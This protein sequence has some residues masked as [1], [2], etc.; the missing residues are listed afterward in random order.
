MAIWIRKTAYWILGVVAAC[1][2][3]G[4][5]VLV[6][7]FFAD[8]RR[9]VVQDLLSQQIGQPLIIQT[10]VRAFVAPTTHVTVSG[11]SIPSEA[12]DGL[13]LAELN[14]LEFDLDLVSMITGRDTGLDNVKINGLTV[15]LFTRIDGVRSWKQSPQP[16]VEPGQPNPGGV[17]EQSGIIAFL[18]KK[19]VNVSS[20][21]LDVKNETT[22]FE[23][24]FAL[25]TARLEQQDGGAAVTLFSRGTV[26]DHPMEVTGYYPQGASFTTS[27][28]L[29]GIQ[30]TFDGNRIPEDAGGG[31]A[32]ILTLD[33]GELGDL[34]EVLRLDR[35]LEGTAHLTAR[36]LRQGT[37]LAVEDLGI[38]ADFPNG[39]TVAVEGWSKDLFTATDFDLKINGQF[40]PDGQQPRTAS[41]LSELELVSLAARLI[42]DA[43]DI[44]VQDALLKTNLFDAG[45]DEIGPISVGR[46]VRTTAGTLA[47]QNIEAQAGP[48]DSPYLTVAGQIEDLLD[49]QD[50]DFSGELNA[51]AQ[52]LMSEFRNDVVQAFGGI[53][54][55]FEISDESGELSLKK[56]EAR[57]EN[58]DLWTMRANASARSVTSVDEVDFE[59]DLDVPDG[60]AFLEAL[61]LKSVAIG[62]VGLSTSA[63]GKNESVETRVSVSV[64]ESSIDTQLDTTVDKNGRPTVRGQIYSR[65]L[66]MNDLD[67][68]GEAVVQL[69]SLDNKDTGANSAQ[70]GTANGAPS[71][72]LQPLVLD[73]GEETTEPEVPE[74]AEDGRI[75]QPLV[76]E[77]SVA[78]VETKASGPDGNGRTVQ[79]LVLADQAADGSPLDL[80]NPTRIGRDLDLE[81]GIE[82]EKIVGQAGVSKISSKLKSKNGKAELVP[83]EFNYGGGY[84]RVGASVD[85]I[86]APQLA[87]VFGATGGW[88]FGKILEEVGADINAYGKLRAD[89]DLTGNH[90]S[91]RN[92]IDSMYGSVTVSMANGKIASSLLELAG[93]GLF[94]WLFS[95]ELQQGYTD[96]VCVVAP[97]RI[98][99]GKMTSNAIVVET[100][101]VQLVA[102]GSVDWRKDQIGIRAEPRP[103]GRPLARTAWPFEVKGRLSNPDFKIGGKSGQKF[104]LFAPKTGQVPTTRKPCKPDRLQTQ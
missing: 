71:R 31:F 53:V 30:L 52:L 59:L 13:N 35:S 63:G 10:D 48:I 43:G 70:M 5:L 81:I 58:T 62:P 75:V 82:V 54:A 101:R 93:L 29:G 89:F 23:F 24:L 14:L 7:P 67:K 3:F 28:S 33:T 19:T 49:L 6:A 47:M 46:V 76:L 9:T 22:G 65:L 73:R 87:H 45:L 90:S 27:A 72:D 104:K 61:G 25:E 26:N 8:I 102:S 39:P 20:V 40:F 2:L 88:D 41:K 66:N 100:K 34:L 50:L 103:V 15:N 36:L 37:V 42:G 1:A 83:V 97:L 12:V 78:D 96:I 18:S 32:G 74:Q 38:D 84:F 57:S 60:G 98:N 17:H 4:W 64:G 44:E 85:F 80:V 69:M 79:P 11:V 68:T 92:F 91:V 95:N 16:A 21:N 86:E 77:P 55:E 99:T 56:L 94:P 51:P